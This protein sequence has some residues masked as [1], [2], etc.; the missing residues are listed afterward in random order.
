MNRRV[1]GEKLDIGRDVP[2]FLRR[3]RRDERAQ[4]L[5][6]YVVLM[7][8]VMTLCFYLYHPDNGFY[9]AARARYDLTTFLLQLP[10][11]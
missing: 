6:E 3:F 10:G 8:V 1:K 9:H 11:P 7:L 4:A 2:A 5:T